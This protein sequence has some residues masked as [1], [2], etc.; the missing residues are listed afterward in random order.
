MILTGSVRFLGLGRLESKPPVWACDPGAPSWGEEVAPGGDDDDGSLGRVSLRGGG[1]SLGV[2]L[3]V[4][5]LGAG[6]TENSPLATLGDA[7]S[8]PSLSLSLL[9]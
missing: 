3:D 7:A 4:A 1:A 9:P 5:V 6:S 8:S 2:S